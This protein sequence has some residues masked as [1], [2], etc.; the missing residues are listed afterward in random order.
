MRFRKATTTCLMRDERLQRLLVRFSCC[1]ADLTLTSGVLGLAKDFG[2]GHAAITAATEA[3]FV[4]LCTGDSELAKSMM[5][6]VELLCV[7]A[8]SDELFAWRVHARACR[9]TV[10]C[11]HA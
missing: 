5:Q 9:R 6:R 3:M 7:D 4:R 10:A 2:T 1:S 11:L 8:S